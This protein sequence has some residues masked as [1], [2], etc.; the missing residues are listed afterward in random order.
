MAVTAQVEPAP[1]AD[2]SLAWSR[3]RRGPD[4]W[5]IGALALFAGL[6][7]WVL[8]YDLW[9]VGQSGRVW[10]GTDGIFPGDQLQ[11]M[12][13]VRDASH[14]V[15]ISDTYVLRG[16]P[17]D[18]LEP[19]FALA[20]GLT[21]LGLAPWVALL[22][23]QPL[24]VAAICFAVLT[25]L[26]RGLSGRWE[27]RV[28][29]IL[30][31]FSGPFVVLIAP[32][33]PVADEWVSFWTWG[34][35][36]AVFALAA[37]VG[38]LVAYDRAVKLSRTL[39]LAPLLGLLASWLHPWQGEELLLILLVYELGRRLRSGAVT[40]SQRSLPGALARPC[41]GSRRWPRWLL[42]C[43][44]SCSI[45]WIRSGTWP[46]TRP[47]CTNRRPRC[48]CPWYRCW[49]WRRWAAADAR[50]PFWRHPAGSGP[51]PL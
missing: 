15:L 1:S 36:P 24:A 21:A 26:H 18:Y 34:Y 10:T 29:L 37:L 27:R 16:T 7:I 13:W 46:R 48:C 17:H 51:W 42:S 47:P 23:F 8:G 41:C 12:A 25:Y 39:W 45:A 40:W 3:P 35:L 50:E 6:S 19:L 20:G 43:I 38:A 30:A 9:Q 33:G 4:P 5:V 14:H 2:R 31:L 49:P 11:Y 44:T 32:F 22:V 28:A